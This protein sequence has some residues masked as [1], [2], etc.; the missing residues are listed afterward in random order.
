MPKVIIYGGKYQ[1]AKDNELLM[2]YKIIIFYILCVHNLQIPML[3]GERS[4]TMRGRRGR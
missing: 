4:R 2:P 3:S 1:M